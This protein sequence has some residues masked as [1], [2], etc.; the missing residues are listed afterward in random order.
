LC[1]PSSSVWCC[2]YYCVQ[3]TLKPVALPYVCLMRNVIRE[4]KPAL[5]SL[6]PSSNR[7]ANRLQICL[8]VE[9]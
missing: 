2:L 7:V 9:S 4:T 6:D 8:N 3:V 1:V 5:P